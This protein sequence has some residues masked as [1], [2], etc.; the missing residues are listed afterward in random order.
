MSM[1]KECSIHST[2]QQLFEHSEIDERITSSSSSEDADNLTNGNMLDDRDFAT[3]V[4]QTV[5]LVPLARPSVTVAPHPMTSSTNYLF[6]DKPPLEQILFFGAGLGSSVCYIA[7]LSSLVH[8]KLLYGANSFVYLNLAVYLPLLPISLAQARWDQS[9]DLQYSSRVTFLVRGMVGYLLG[10]LG[11]ILMIRKD[12]N[13]QSGLTNLIIHTLLQGTGGAILYGTLNQ[14]ASFVGG[15]DGQSL[16]AAVSAGVQASAVVVLAVSTVTGF[17]THDASKFSWFLWNIV[18]VESICF[19]GFILLLLARPTVAIAMIRRDSSL[20]LDADFIGDDALM[21]RPLVVISRNPVSPTLGL[22]FLA[23][24]EKSKSCCFVLMATLIP[25]FLVGSWF[26]RVQT[27][28]IR[29]ASCLFYVRIV[30]DFLGRF[31]TIIIP[32][33]NTSCLINTCLLRLVPIA[34]FFMNAHQPTRFADALSIGLVA[35]IAF[36]SGYLVTGCYQFAPLE[37]DWEVREVNAAK[38]ASLLTV[39]FSVSAIGGLLSSFFL[40]VLGV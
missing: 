15:D 12:G 3:P 36:L 30:S 26:T 17:G 19:V 29:L 10:L 18:G 7:T 25:S 6:N 5:A 16:K 31:A 35:I 38:Q 22:S 27:N 20:Q 9:I 21:E 11:T 1:V 23:L 32:P 4:E 39:A 14:L 37:L 28:W 24:L 33:R 8:F 13:P 2:S 40:M 34:L